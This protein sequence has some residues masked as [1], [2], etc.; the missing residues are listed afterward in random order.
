ML[1]LFMTTMPLLAFVVHKDFLHVNHEWNFILMKEHPRFQ[2]PFSY[3]KT[4]ALKETTDAC[5]GQ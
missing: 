4:K 5:W 2:S 3:R 1:Y